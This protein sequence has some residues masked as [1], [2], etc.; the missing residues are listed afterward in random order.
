MDISSLATLAGNTLVAVAVT[1]AWEDVRQKIARLFGRGQPD[2]GSE[3]K[4]DATRQQLDTARP[5]ELERV[6]AD[7]SHEWAVRFKDL[8]AD[9]PDAGPE[10]AMLVEE[11]KPVIA[12][13]AEGSVA[14]ARDVNVTAD[15]GSLAAGVIQGDV[16]LPGPRAPG[17]EGGWPGPG[18]QGRPG[19]AR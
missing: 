9:H 17:P 8:L 15:H 16:T 7:L 14:A 6:R 12:T 1:D 11:I 13:A 4:L 18:S 3:R 5:A 19:L 10:L 2:P